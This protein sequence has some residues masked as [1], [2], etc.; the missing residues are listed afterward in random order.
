MTE[1]DDTHT[2]AHAHMFGITLRATA[3]RTLTQTPIQMKGDDRYSLGDEQQRFQDTDSVPA[4][5]SATD[6]HCILTFSC[7]F[8]C[9]CLWTCLDADRHTCTVDFL[10]KPPVSTWSAF[11]SLF[12][13]NEQA[14]VSPSPQTAAVLETSF[15]C[16]CLR[17]CILISSGCC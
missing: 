13:H 17:W 2:H 10:H 5:W 6:V 11:S 1:S 9:F 4:C 15:G 14:V 7:C 8:L 16:L 12:P 3:Q